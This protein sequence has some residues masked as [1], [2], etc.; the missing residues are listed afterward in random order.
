MN[1]PGVL[2]FAL[3]LAAWIALVMWVPDLGKCK[4]KMAGRRCE[5]RRGHDGPHGFRTYS[6]PMETTWWNNEGRNT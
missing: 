4:A 2:V 6:L 5:L 1:W 3:G